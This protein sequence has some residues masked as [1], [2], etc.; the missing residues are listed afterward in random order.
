MLD[1]GS[2]PYKT[3]GRI[4]VLYI[5]T[6][7]FLDSWQEDRRLKN[8]HITELKDAMEDYFSLNHK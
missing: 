3:T 5:L 6:F 2:Y 1:Q 8:I 4:M 7:M